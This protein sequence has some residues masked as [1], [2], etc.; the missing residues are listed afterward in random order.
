MAARCEHGIVFR[1]C[2]CRDFPR[3]FAIV[4]AGDHF[5]AHTL[6]TSALAWRARI[7]ATVHPSLF[8]S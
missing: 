6:L 5:S 8:C 2:A 4:Q 7:M 1:E 3:G